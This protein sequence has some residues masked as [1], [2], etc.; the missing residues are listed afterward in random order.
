[1]ENWAWLALASAFA[2]WLLWR[3]L[4]RPDAEFHDARRRDEA[5]RR[6]GGWET[7]PLDPPEPTVKVVPPSE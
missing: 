7:I 5:L 4:T 6:M 2:C 1:M 3:A